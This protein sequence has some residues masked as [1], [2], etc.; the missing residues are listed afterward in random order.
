[1]SFDRLG[2]FGIRANVRIRKFNKS[3]KLLQEFIGN[4]RITK[5]GLVGLIKFVNG[6]FNDSNYQLISGYIPT[7]L[8]VGTNRPDISV[9]GITTEVTV[10]D[11]RLLSEI[12]P[13]VKITRRNS[14]ENNH[15]DEYIKLIIRCYIPTDYYQGETIREAGLFCSDSGNNCWARIIVPDMYKDE[16]SVIDVTWE[17]T[18][19]SM[20]SES[21]PYSQNQTSD[22]S[23]LG[24]RLNQYGNPDL[25][26]DSSYEAFAP[27]YSISQA[28]FAYENA[29]QASVNLQ[30]SN[31]E[32][33]SQS[34]VPVSSL[35]VTSSI[36]GG[37]TD[38]STIFNYQI[39]D[40]SGNIVA[41]NGENTFQLMNN[42]IITITK[43]IVGE[44]YSL[45]ETGNT[46]NY[47]NAYGSSGLSITIESSSNSV[48][49][50]NNP[51]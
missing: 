12:S 17:I 6:E 8:G 51:S 13:R 31:I 21:Q 16:D 45:I 33:A 49:F 42:G 7:Y 1:M 41:V 48:T 39:K 11:S 38:N 24:N 15:N 18:V 25:Y 23:V 46:S 9:T 22:K 50:V 35:T 27:V 34:L 3:G 28:V 40:S 29:T 2:Q 14:V 32:S 4:N 5:L 26:S 10:N 36:S 43:L 37:V 44:N 20:K 30:V 19:I 47:T